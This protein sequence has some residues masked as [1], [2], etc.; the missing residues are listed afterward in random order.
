[1][2][3]DPLD[4]PPIQEIQN[5]LTVAVGQIGNP[6]ARPR[7]LTESE[8]TATVQD[9]TLVANSS[10]S[11]QEPSNHASTT[12]IPTMSDH[13][14]DSHLAVRTEAINETSIVLSS[15]S[16]DITHSTEISGYVHCHC[17][18]NSYNIKKILCI[19]SV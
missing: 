8:E 4:E 7:E 1:M 19:L 14:G 11:H 15:A 5:L 2:P 13:G 9:N 12:S 3:E 6:N 10:A 18:N 16:P 17:G